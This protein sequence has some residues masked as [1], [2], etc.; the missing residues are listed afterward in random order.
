MVVLFFAVSCGILAE[1]WIAIRLEAWWLIGSLSLAAC[2]GVRLHPIG[3]TLLLLLASACSGGT[4]S[5]VHWHFFSHEDVAVY[6]RGMQRGMQTLSFRRRLPI[7]IRGELLEEPLRFHPDTDPNQARCQ[8]QLQLTGIRL[9]P[10]RWQP[11]QGVRSL[12][13]IG[14][15]PCYRAGDTVEVWGHL[16]QPSPPRNPG[17]R[18]RVWSLRAKR[19]LGRLVTPHPDCVK[20]LTS[21]EDWRYPLQRARSWCRAVIQRYM[22]DQ[23]G[24]AEALFLGDRLQL[25]PQLRETFEQTG[26]AHLLA[27]SGLHVGILAALVL[28]FARGIPRVPQQLALLATVSIVVIY[29]GLTGGR[30]PVFRATT[31]VGLA[32]FSWV[33]RRRLSPFN[34]LA[35]AGLAVLAGRPSELFQTGTQLSFLAVATLIH[36]GHHFSTEENTDPI[37]RLIR[38]SRPRWLQHLQGGLRSFQIMFAASLA[39]WLTTLPITTRSFH[40]L[41]PVAPVLN[42]FLW[43]PLSLAIY[44]IV[45]ILVFHLACPPLAEAL[46]WAGDRALHGLV[47]PLQTAQS[48][49]GSHCWL[50]GPSLTYVIIF[51][52]TLILMMA[53]PKSRGSKRSWGAFGVLAV[54]A[55]CLPSSKPLSHDAV[56]T[57]IFSVGHGACALIEY[58]NDEV[59]LI[60]A[61]SLAARSSV[62]IVSQA[63]WHRRICEIDTVVISHADADHYN[64]LPSLQERFPIRRIIATRRTFAAKELIPLLAAMKPSPELKSVAQ[65][66][67]LTVGPCRIRLHQPSQRTLAT[68]R[69]DNASSLVFTI[70]CHEHSFLFPGDID[71]TGLDELLCGPPEDVD[72]TLAPHHGSPGSRPIPFTDWS[73]PEYVI[74]SGSKPTYARHYLSAVEDRSHVLHTETNGAITI[75]FGRKCLKVT[76]TIPTK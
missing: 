46:G 70:E 13:V 17:E 32:S 1:C 65:G 41:T 16:T 10:Q 35:T 4:L 27:V 37:A 75:T 42:T 51:Y 66:D 29:A 8:V 7:C 59:W 28:F 43:I 45:G 5:Q 63:L 54:G 55:I 44:S 2:W 22:T 25:S 38:R 74:I 68:A 40:L 47:A 71:G 57:T 49:S 36:V 56:R 15:L 64:I 20:L 61:G 3:R 33:A 24:L 12:T 58:P 73:T 6:E 62:E 48:L 53:H 9:S 23:S 72:V 60:D 39:V 18:D 76:P 19:R 69:T 21:S 30:A 14:E 11:V 26:T 52:T 31:F 67:Q 50:A 34:S